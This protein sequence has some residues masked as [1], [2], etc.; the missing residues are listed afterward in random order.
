MRYLCIEN[1]RIVSAPTYEPSVPD[2]VEVVTI[3]DAEYDDIHQHGTH[4]FDMSTRKVLPLTAD[5]QSAKT[6]T[7]QESDARIFLRSTDWKVLRHVRE[8][9]LGKTTTLS[10]D[11]YLALERERD[12]AAELIR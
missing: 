10:Q 11:E 7:Q 8:Q 9:A 4:Y 6:Q 2:S 12:A 1:Q 3:T 5:M